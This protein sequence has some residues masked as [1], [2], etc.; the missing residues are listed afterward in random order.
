MV[1]HPYEHHRF[2]LNEIPNL[3]GKV[4]IDCGCGKGVWGYLMRSEKEGDTAFIFAFDM[5]KPYLEFCKKYRVYDDLILAD[6]K[7]MPFMDRSF[8]VVLAPELI[9]HLSKEGGE[10]FLSEVDRICKDVAIITTPNGLWP[11]EAHRSSWGFKNFKVRGYKLRGIGF[12][13]IKR[14]YVSRQIWGIFCYI[15]TPLA[16][17]LPQLG[18][19]LVAVKKFHRGIQDECG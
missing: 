4:V 2:V 7:H 11:T 3:N 6:A 12:R 13:L 19:W 18:E 17:V 10:R 16:Y 14:P 8:D 5:H 1:L 9:E 15:F